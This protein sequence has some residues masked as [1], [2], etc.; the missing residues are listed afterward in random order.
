MRGPVLEDSCCLDLRW[1]PRVW[2]R[3]VHARL[4]PPSGNPQATR[5]PQDRPPVLRR[6]MTT[7]D[8]RRSTLR[9][10][11]PRLIS[12]STP[13]VKRLGS[14]YLSTTHCS[15]RQELTL[16]NMAN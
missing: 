6:R 10:V 11:A 12:R 5:P 7:T 15:L 13:P 2:S 9:W 3:R 8:P 1:L 16:G 4:R 14:A